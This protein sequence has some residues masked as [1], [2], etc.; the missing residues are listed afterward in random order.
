MLW[1][2]K[3][4]NEAKSH[5]N[6]ANYTQVKVSVK[7]EIAETF[8]NRCRAGGV[9]MAGE[10]SRFMSGETQKPSK[11]PAPSYGTRQRRRKALAD[12]IRLLQA[13]YDAESAYMDNIPVNLQNSQVYESAERAVTAFNDA[14]D[15]LR[16]AY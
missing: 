9:S 12:L 16:E 1:R 15:I 8:R 5:W 2:G 6:A 14:L 13:I 10:L 4:S 7:P 11:N 3:T